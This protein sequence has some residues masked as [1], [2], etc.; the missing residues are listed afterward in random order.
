VPEGVQI[1][2]DPSDHFFAANEGYAMPETILFNGEG[3]IVLQQRG[4]LNA[5]EM[6]ATIDNLLNE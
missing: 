1:V 4:A 2:L 3:A 6:R 5:N